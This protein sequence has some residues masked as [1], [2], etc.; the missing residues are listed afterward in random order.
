MR[1]ILHAHRDGWEAA[2]DHPAAIVVDYQTGHLRAGTRRLKIM[3]YR[4]FPFLTFLLRSA[5]L[6]QTRPAIS[7]A[8]WATPGN[9]DTHITQIAKASSPM[10]EWLEMTLETLQGVG[11]RLH[12]EPRKS[13]Q[14]CSTLAPG[15]PLPTQ[16]RSTP[17]E[18]GLPLMTSAALRHQSTRFSRR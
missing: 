14:C 17:R 15:Q 13:L 1:Q 9:W 6:V 12:S 16:V 10:L 18:H 3:G 2:L 5:D 7:Q 8:V 11:Y 4:V